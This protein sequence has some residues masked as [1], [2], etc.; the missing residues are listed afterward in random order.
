MQNYFDSLES[1]T[2][3][4]FEVIVIDDNSDDNEIYHID[5]EFDKRGIKHTIIINEKNYGPGISRNKG[6]ERACGE[7]ILFLDADDWMESETLALLNEVAIQ[8]AGVEC[9]MF[10]Y[11][12]VVEGKETKHSIL[13]SVDNNK[14][15][16]KINTSSMGKAY[17]RDFI[18]KKNIKFYPAYL[19]EDFYFTIAAINRCVSFYHI[20]K[21]LYY[22]RMNNNSITH[23]IDIDRLNTIKEIIDTL[24]KK[25][26]INKEEKRVFFLREY[27]YTLILSTKGKRNR[28][29]DVCLQD[30]RSLDIVKYAKCLCVHQTLFLLLYKFRL[31]KIIE[32]GLRICR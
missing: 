10:D 30:Y 16:Y 6:I 23:T 2:Y 24:E 29:V 1:Q 32:I 15:L 25:E 5:E 7:Y 26:F 13:S 12:V 4:D 11:A 19:A 28:E 31:N 9:I 27:L 14:L 21:T 20:K 17:R 22:Y 3:E 8:N 18:L